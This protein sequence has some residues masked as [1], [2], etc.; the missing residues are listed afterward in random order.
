MAVSDGLLQMRDVIQDGLCC[1]CV[2]A[3]VCVCM[4]VYV[5]M[6]MYVCVCMYMHVCM[7]ACMYVCT[8]EIERS[9]KVEKVCE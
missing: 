9:W 6:C 8:S 5:C 2:C 7:H 4:Y 1:L 3:R